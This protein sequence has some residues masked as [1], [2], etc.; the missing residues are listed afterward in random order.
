VQIVI[1]ILGEPCHDSM[2]G[3]AFESTVEIQIGE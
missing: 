2:S 3:E 1:R